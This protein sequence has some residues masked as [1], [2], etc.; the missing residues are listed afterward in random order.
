MAFISE[1]DV[2]I[3]GRKDAPR[4][5]NADKSQYHQ[6]RGTNNH[7]RQ[8][9]TAIKTRPVKLRMGKPE[10]IADPVGI[11]MTSGGN[12]PPKVND[13]QTMECLIIVHVS[14]RSVNVCMSNEI[15]DSA[16]VSF[17]GSI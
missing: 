13:A 10:N 17:L 5:N 15:S 6:T 7:T 1:H 4:N 11:V 8:I 3:V 16:H 2:H 12:V 9:P 14:V